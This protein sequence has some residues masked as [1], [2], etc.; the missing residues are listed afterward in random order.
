MCPAAIH[1]RILLIL[2]HMARSMT[3]T[4]W[5]PIVACTPYQMQAEVQVLSVCSQQH[6]EQTN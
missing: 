2:G 3:N 4:H 5:P 1:S 6:S